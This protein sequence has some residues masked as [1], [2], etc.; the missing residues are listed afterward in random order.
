MSARNRDV[1]EFVADLVRIGI[2]ELAAELGTPEEDGQRAM[3]RIADGIC[4]EY[5]RREIYVPAAYDPR[6]REIV[7]AYHQSTSTARAVTPERVAELAAQY[8]LT[9]RQ[10]YS[11]LQAAREADMATRQGVLQ[12]DLGE[13]QVQGE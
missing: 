13:D 9:T 11:I 2:R 1:K 5:A 8:G 3:Q 6:N 10:V 7:A 12:L 4:L